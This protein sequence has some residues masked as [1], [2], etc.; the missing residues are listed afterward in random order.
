MGGRKLFVKICGI[1]NIEDALKCVDAGADA[2]G[3]V[4]YPH[5]PRY[6]SPRKVKEIISG[7]PD[8]ILTFGVFVNEP[9]DIVLKIQEQSSI[10]IVQLHGNEPPEWVSILRDK[11]VKVC[12]V[13][14][15][16]KK[17][18][19]QDFDS[20]SFEVA[21]VESG[22]SGY[23]GTGKSW[24]WPDIVS[25]KRSFGNRK[26]FPVLL[27]GGISEK[28]VA[29]AVKKA[30]PDGIDLSSGVEKYPGKKD[31]SKLQEL[32]DKLRL[33]PVSWEVTGFNFLKK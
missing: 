9:P 33:F 2:L 11:G 12:K 27:A 8:C 25:L 22:K 5:S 15:Q 16:Y 28:N 17:P 21:L 10:D 20:Y 14:F 24:A 23:G 13:F 26:T 32:M 1:T 31:Q 18:S 29:E 30:C 19:F 3:F 7:L 4:F 6:V